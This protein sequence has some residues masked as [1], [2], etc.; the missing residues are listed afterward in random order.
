VAEDRKSEDI[1]DKAFAENFAKEW[2]AAWNSHDL[3]RILEHYED[4]FEMSSPIIRT[5]AGEP[6]GTLRGKAAVRSYWAKALEK[7]PDL[8]FELLTVLAGVN[9]VTVYYK[10][11]R[12]LSAEV[13][14]F[15]PGG[16]VRAAFAHYAEASL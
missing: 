9:S 15:G 14:H 13:F 5:L 6:S 1:M 16:K 11:H 7:A 8:H 2:I 12:G 3:D 4:N 10:G